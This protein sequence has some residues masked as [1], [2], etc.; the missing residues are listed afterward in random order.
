MNGDYKLIKTSK[1]KEHKSTKTNNNKKEECMWL[2]GFTK[3]A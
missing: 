2:S 3:K 1:I